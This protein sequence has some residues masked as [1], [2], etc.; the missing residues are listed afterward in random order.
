[1]ELVLDDG[2]VFLDEPTAGLDVSSA[3]SLIRV[4]KRYIPVVQSMVNFTFYYS[5]T[6]GK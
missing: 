5:L 3:L 6:Q 2:V 1:M 4:L